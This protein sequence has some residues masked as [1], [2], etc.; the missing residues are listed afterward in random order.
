MKTLSSVPATSAYLLAL[1]ATTA[2]LSSSSAQD[3]DQLLL[4]VSTN[5][6]QLTHDPVRVLVASAFWTSGWWEL[7]LWTVL[8]AVILAP[9][10]RRLGWRRTTLTFAAG[11][12]GAT[13]I[14]AAG[15]W[16]GIQL[17]AGDPADVVA[18]DVGASY[19]FFAV[20]ALA[21]YL[22][23]PRNRISY[24][25][26]I[27]GYVVATAALFHTFTDFGHLAAVAIGL[28]CYPLVRAETERS[29]DA[30]HSQELV[31]SFSP[32]S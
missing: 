12:L 3:D 5:L 32:S 10:E 15:L 30:L 2:V 26:A 19:G 24:L 16:I 6:H 13:L 23:A 20:A 27:I 31:R 28:A 8:F 9:V 1:V 18:R 11:H 25:A 14:I 4:S 7:A 22:L 29:S 21:G 17:G